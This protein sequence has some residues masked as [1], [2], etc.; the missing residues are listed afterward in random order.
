MRR[1]LDLAGATLLA[2]A[3][4]WAL[5]GGRAPGDRVSPLVVAYL[6]TGLAF[7]C[8]RVAARLGGQAAAGTLVVGAGLV[9]LGVSGP[10][11]VGSTGASPFGYGNA[12][13]ALYAQVAIAALFVATTVGAPSGR[14]DA[15]V[16]G[17]AG[18]RP[19]ARRGGLININEAPA[20]RVLALGAAGLF[21]L[22][23][24]ASGSLM[25]VLCLAAAGVL[26]R[27]A[28]GDGGT[29]LAAAA[30]ACATVLALGLTAALALRA[31]PPRGPEAVTVRVQRWREAASLLRAHPL[32]G[33]GAGRFAEL[34][35][36]WPDADL[37]WA[38][39]GFLQ[40]G[41]EQGAVGLALLLG[42]ITWGLVRCW[43][44]SD[45]TLAP[46]VGAAAITALA[47]HASVDYVLHFGA[48]PMTAA[49]VAGAAT[50]GRPASTAPAAPASRIGPPP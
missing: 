43:R 8:G 27:A 12:N 30:G 7:A 23:T 15:R 47:L 39:S 19:G 14:P 41:A 48:L 10:L 11:D 29:A 1:S 44:T 50:L 5:T 28:R 21:A 33:V 34:T 2:A 32:D 35:G 36:A 18:P 9:A 37:R 38:H 46:A 20:G 13:G 31:E 6:T 49:F 17:G 42:L 22:F 25:A 26:L 40:Q 3:V 16:G 4:G 45:D 24:V